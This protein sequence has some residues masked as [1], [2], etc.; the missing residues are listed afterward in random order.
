MSVPLT[1]DSSGSRDR[2]RDGF[3]DRVPVAG[4]AGARLE[5]LSVRP[6]LSGTPGFEDA[7]RTRA[8]ALADF[9]DPSF[10]AVRSVERAA[11][12]P[13][14]LTITA[15]RP[16]GVRL[17]FLLDRARSGALDTTPRV[18][19]A[20]LRQLVPAF[21]RLHAHGVGLTH[22]ALAPER[23]IVTPNGR[24]SVTDTVFGSALE[25][26]GLPRR[27][28]WQTFRVAAPPAAGTVRLDERADLIQVGL[29]AL[30]LLAG[31]PIET[32]EFP[33]RLPMLAR[34]TIGEWTARGRPVPASVATWLLHTLQID[35]R[36]S[37]ATMADALTALNETPVW[38]IDE[39]SAFRVLAAWAGGETVA[40]VARREQVI[41]LAASGPAPQP[42]AG[43][44]TARDLVQAVGDINVPPPARNGPVAVPRPMARRAAPPRP[45]APPTSA[46]RSAAPSP[47]LPPA[48]VAGPSPALPPAASAPAADSR[49]TPPPAL[50][51]VPRPTPQPV[52]VAALW[53]DASPAS[54]GRWR[55]RL[56]M[57]AAAVALAAAGVFG[58]QRY[59]LSPG[60]GTLSVQSDPQG[61]AVNVDGEL[62]GVTPI[63]LRLAA[64]SHMVELGWPGGPRVLPIEIAAGERISQQVSFEAPRSARSASG[65]VPATGWL[66]V[67]A[68]FDVKVLEN[69]QPLEVGEDGRIKLR[70]G[71][72]SLQVTSEA[73]GFHEVRAA[74]IRS[75]KLTQLIIEAPVGTVHLNARPW[76]EVWLDGRRVGETPIGNLAVPIGQHE[77]VFRNPE[78]GEKRYDVSV[79]LLAPTHLTVDMHQ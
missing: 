51:A 20:A 40:R 25:R 6:E 62:R 1:A 10:A 29:V 33:E 36:R 38:Q 45:A 71:R 15:D 56:P 44:V 46:P 12:P 8:A 66:A 27:A 19:I 31:R 34:G 65:E 39:G 57:I 61:V 47:V 70:P 67:V 11:S 55:S 28:L 53:P 50:S 2:F 18:A 4:A 69:G 79:T 21:V 74:E 22:G 42:P 9:D 73:L 32:D 68:T 37:L 17:S 3:G 48:S 52:D 72:H 59:L 13:G 41:R 16:E 5:L 63:E 35:P 58:A 7:V 76:A 64:G 26:L 49:P 75:G 60:F 24:L 23:V 78:L 14:P 54:G 30:A 77:F 43:N